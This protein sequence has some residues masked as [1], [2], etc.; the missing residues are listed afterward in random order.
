[1]EA[2]A[3]S[4]I[5]GRLKVALLG[6]LLIA[7]IAGGYAIFMRFPL[8]CVSMAIS[9]A[10]GA[11]GE[12]SPEAA[13]QRWR[14][15]SGIPTPHFGWE[16]VPRDGV[17]EMINGRWKVEVFDLTRASGSGWLVTQSTC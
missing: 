16:A 4:R 13:F 12:D 5:S 2:R 1:M 9:V 17:I 3:G 15:E 10:E 7:L 6:L 8:A 14:A 11:V